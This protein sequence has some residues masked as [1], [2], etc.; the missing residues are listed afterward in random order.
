MS[1]KKKNGKTKDSFKKKK[2]CILNTYVLKFSYNF[3]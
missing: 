3:V 1:L 2:V